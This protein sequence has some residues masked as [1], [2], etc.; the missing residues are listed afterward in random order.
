MFNPE[1]LSI[2]GRK[3]CQIEQKTILRAILQDPIIES[4][5]NQEKFLKYLLNDQSNSISIF[6]PANIAANSLGLDISYVNL[7]SSNPAQPVKPDILQKANDIYQRVIVQKGFQANLENAIFVS[8][9]LRES[10]I[11][12]KTWLGISRK[13]NFGKDGESEERGQFMDNY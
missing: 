13:I 10:F 11:Q 5:V 9:F 8:F 7:L 6:Q 12:T 2:L 3:Y 1:F 4:Y